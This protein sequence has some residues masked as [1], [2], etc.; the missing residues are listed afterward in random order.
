MA[1]STHHVPP[2]FFL[3]YELTAAWLQEHVRV[4][5]PAACDVDEWLN[6]HAEIGGT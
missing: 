1:K 4:A 5:L 3:M 6:H 2:R